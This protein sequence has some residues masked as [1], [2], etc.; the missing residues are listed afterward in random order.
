MDRYI[1]C[2]PRKSRPALRGCIPPSA[3]KRN[4]LDTRGIERWMLQAGQHPKL[5]PRRNGCTSPVCRGRGHR[6]GGAVYTLLA[7]VSVVFTVLVLGKYR[8]IQLPKNTPLPTPP[9]DIT[10]LGPT[11]ATLNCPGSTFHGNTRADQATLNEAPRGEPALYHAA[12]K[13]AVMGHSG[14]GLGDRSTQV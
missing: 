8:T 3:P 11:L 4:R 2:G 13:S 14:S 9:F 5:G 6:A 7:L 12:M 1:Q 10:A